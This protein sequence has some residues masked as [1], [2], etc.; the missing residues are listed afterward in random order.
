M[1]K[2]HTIPSSIKIAKQ[3]H[4]SGK[5]LVLAGGCFDLLHLGHVYFLEQAKK[6]GD[7][8]MLLLES[9]DT[10]KKLKGDKRPIN[11]QKNRAK[12]LAAFEAV[13]YVAVLPA[14]HTNK[15]YDQLVLRLKP[16]IIATTKGDLFQ[17]HKRRQANLIDAK[18]VSV[19][20]I[21]D[22][23]TSQLAKQIFDEFYL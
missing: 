8:L 19:K 5:K 10:V 20:K 6:Q 11:T 14:L 18:I 16:A 17:K 13:D 22:Y 23:S 1:S 12:M 3:I 9:D 7:F 15:E 4:S 21:A 2:I